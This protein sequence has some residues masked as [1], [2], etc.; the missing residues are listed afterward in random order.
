M[1]GRSLAAAFDGLRLSEAALLRAAALLS[2]LRLDP[3]QSIIR[4][5]VARGNS[6]RDKAKLALAAACGTLDREGA[7]PSDSLLAAAYLAAAA[8]RHGA[9]PGQEARALRDVAALAAAILAA[10][11]PLSPEHEETLRA[12]VSR[13]LNQADKRR[14]IASLQPPHEIPDAT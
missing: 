3:M 14:V 10:E 2:P 12:A 11:L 4:G 13:R 9:A 8:V 1:T 7:G 6:S 5:Y